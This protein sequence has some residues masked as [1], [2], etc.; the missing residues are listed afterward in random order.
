MLGPLR[1]HVIYR[2]L[3]WRLPPI[4][5]NSHPNRDYA[6]TWQCPMQPRPPASIPTRARFWLSALTAIYKW[7][8]PSS[9]SLISR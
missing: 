6:A 1:M 3:L 5:F 2:E 9:L 4:T 8:N 7:S